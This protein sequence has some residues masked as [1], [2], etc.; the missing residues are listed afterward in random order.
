MDVKQRDHVLESIYDA[1]LDASRW[2]DAVLSIAKAM[3]CLQATFEIHDPYAGFSKWLAP[4]SDPDFKQSHVAYY[5]KLFTLSGKVGRFR[6]G[7][8]FDSAHLGLTSETF[9]ASEFYNEWWLP[10]GTG[11]ATL[12]ANVA[13]DGRATASVTLYKRSGE[14]S[15]EPEQRAEFGA[16]VN[17]LVRAVAIHRRLHLADAVIGACAPS[18]AGFAVIDRDR[19]VLHADEATRQRLS[20]ARLLKSDG[21]HDRIVSPDG[22]LEPLI[23]RAACRRA[24]G[25]RAAGDYIGT[26]PDGGQLV[27]TISPCSERGA[28]QWFAI[29]RPA[30]VLTISDPLDRDRARLDR[31]VQAHGLT[32]GEAAVAIE[33][34]RGDGRDA[35]AQR[36]GLRPATVR[37]HLTAIFDKLAIHR[38]AELARIVAN[39]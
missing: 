4:L 2:E 8:L 1:A 7:E 22:R 18:A 3:D 10:Q 14:N 31:L 32:R 11:G 38:Q 28:H 30:A 12:M 25:M 36:L 27:L 37:S 19:K 24:E 35:A 15:F 6:T 16:V 34:A 20:W 9:R 13:Q 21:L 23:A 33:I 17:H 29:D 39:V 26:T 5:G